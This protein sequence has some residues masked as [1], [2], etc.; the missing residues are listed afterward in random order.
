VSDRDRLERGL[1]AWARGC[2]HCRERI[3]QGDPGAWFGLLRHVPIPGELLEDVSRAVARELSRSE[4]PRSSASRLS[5]WLRWRV[6]WAAV[7]LGAALLAVSVYRKFGPAVEPSGSPGLAAPEPRARIEVV[8]PAGIQ[9]VVDL[10][11]GDT[12]LVMVFSEEI[13]L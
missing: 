2:P 3:E 1:E 11:V 6:A 8:S 10:T 4:S 9:P 13:E 7:V 12:R 5:G